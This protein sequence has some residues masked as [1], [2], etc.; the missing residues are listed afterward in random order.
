MWNRWIVLA[1][2]A[3]QS[4]APPRARTGAASCAQKSCQHKHLIWGKNGPV[5]PSEARVLPTA[6]TGCAQ[7][8][9]SSSRSWA[10]RI[11][12]IAG[13]FGRTRFSAAGWRGSATT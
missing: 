3:G 5:Y 13:F 12:A 8:Q 7:K 2:E 6:I 9:I 1:D 4:M 10:S 11:L